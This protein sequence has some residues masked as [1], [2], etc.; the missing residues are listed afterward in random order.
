[1]RFTSSNK[2]HVGDSQVRNPIVEAVSMSSM[3]RDFRNFSDGGR[4]TYAS[5]KKDPYKADRFKPQKL[6]P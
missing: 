4:S 1:M 5:P 6:I 2:S 3:G